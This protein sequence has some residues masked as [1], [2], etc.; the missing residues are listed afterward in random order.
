MAPND[1]NFNMYDLRFD[2]TNCANLNGAYEGLG[3]LLD[4]LEDGI[5]D[6]ESILA[7]GVD[8]GVVFVAGRLFKDI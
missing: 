5:V 6:A 2:R 7:F 8:N 4:R 3:V 1:P